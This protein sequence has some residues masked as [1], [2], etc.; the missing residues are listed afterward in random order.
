MTCLQL[1]AIEGNCISQRITIFETDRQSKIGKLPS[2]TAQS[3]KG[4]SEA[5]QNGALG[6]K[7][8]Q[9]MRETTSR[10]ISLVIL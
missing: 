2:L 5:M 3:P 8:L 7:F 4:V 1:I 9:N 10:I 6:D